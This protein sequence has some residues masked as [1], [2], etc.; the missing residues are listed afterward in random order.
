MTPNETLQFLR[1]SKFLLAD[2][3]K[4]YICPGSMRIVEFEEVLA[5]G[6]V[7]FH[8]YVYDGKTRYSGY[9]W[10]GVYVANEDGTFRNVHREIK[11]L[12]LAGVLES[13]DDGYP[14]T[15]RVKENA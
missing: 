10:K 11:R 1:S 12:V 8:S 3:S 4:G 5:A 6:C 9:F 15:L 2:R 13:V 14:R 7:R